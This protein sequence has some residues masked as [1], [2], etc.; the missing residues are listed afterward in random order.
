M[1]AVSDFGTFT[2]WRDIGYNFVI[3]GDGHVYEGRGWKVVG[4]HTSGYNKVHVG[5]GKSAYKCKLDKRN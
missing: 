4:A 3:G 2:G 5:H 1:K